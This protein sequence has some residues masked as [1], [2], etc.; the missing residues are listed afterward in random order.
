MTVSMLAAGPSVENEIGSNLEYRIAGTR[1][2]RCAAFE[3][4]YRKYVEAELIKPNRFEFRVTPYHL[5]PT[6]NVFVATEAGQ[7]NCTM[8]LIGD[9]ELGLPMES[10][11]PAEI[12][13]RRRKNLYIGEVSCLAFEPLPLSQF[14]VIF[15]QPPWL[16]QQRAVLRHGSVRDRRPSAACPV[17]S[18]VHGFR[19]GRP[20]EDVP[21]GAP[22]ARRRLL[23]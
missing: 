9:G 14:M 4:V 1:D 11:Y 2:D 16:T 6:T 23:P 10:I 20:L 3:L 18:A 21:V 13:Q 17:L 19:A 7:E 22:C 12:L 8:T 15:M 5:L